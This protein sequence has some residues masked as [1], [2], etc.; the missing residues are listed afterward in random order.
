MHDE[1]LHLKN[2]L[3]RL[4][5]YKP[6]SITFELHA[7]GPHGG[8]HWAVA[9]LSVEDLRKVAQLCGEMAEKAARITTRQ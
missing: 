2:G 6:D 9:E 5:P 1:Y 3:L 7:K 8:E 4:S